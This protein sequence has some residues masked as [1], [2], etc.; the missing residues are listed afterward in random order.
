MLI[1]PT[2]MG[3]FRVQRVVLCVQARASRTNY[4]DRPEAFASEIPCARVAGWLAHSVRAWRQ[5]AHV[6]T[7]A[8]YLPRLSYLLQVGPINGLRTGTPSTG[9]E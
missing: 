1:P 2:T 5:G 3:R 9:R 6:V 8:A 7:T 4:Y